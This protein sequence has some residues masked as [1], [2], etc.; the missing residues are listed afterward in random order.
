M[1]AEQANSMVTKAVG[2]DAD[3]LG[4]LLEHFGPQVGAALRVGRRWQSMIDIGD[5]MQVTYLEAF[6]QI[7]RF[8]VARSGSFLRWLRTI[9]A[10]NLRDAIRGLGG[11]D[12]PPIE[13]RLSAP[14]PRS[15]EDS[16][17]EFVEQLGYTTTTPSRIARRDEAG[18]ILLAAMDRLPSDYREV[19]RRYDL[20]GMP[21]GDVASSIGRSAGAVHMLR[22]RAHARLKELLGEYSDVLGSRA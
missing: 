2:G 5:V 18:R 9:A 19:V 1:N 20:D 3:A 17:S 12:R 21:I 7:G 8:D 13:L 6:L 15:I 14:A 16:A 4:E 11:R 22:A 10:N